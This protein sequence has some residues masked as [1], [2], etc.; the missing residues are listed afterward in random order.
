LHSLVGNHEMNLL[1][2]VDPRLDN[3]YQIRRKCY[4]SSSWNF[5]QSKQG[6]YSNDSNRDLHFRFNMLWHQQLLPAKVESLAMESIK[7]CIHQN[8]PITQN[9][10]FLLSFSLSRIEDYLLP[11][12]QISFVSLLKNM[13]F[14]WFPCSSELTTCLLPDQK[15]NINHEDNKTSQHSWA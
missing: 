5:F 10:I 7:Y 3:I 13:K 2:S 1:T 14:F 9:S 6:P 8:T 4:Y 11:V 15:G 12:N